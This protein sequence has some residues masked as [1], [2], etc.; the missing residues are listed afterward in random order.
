MIRITADLDTKDK[1]KILSSINKA[2]L[3][4]KNIKSLEIKK[5]SRKGYHL[6]IYTTY[7]YSLKKQFELRKYIDDDAYR[8]YMDKQRTLGRNTL[9]NKKIKFNKL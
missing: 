7:P 2:F 6:I 1:I 9:F 8:L 3:K 5:S 4:I